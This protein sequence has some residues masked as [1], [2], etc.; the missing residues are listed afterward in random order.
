VLKGFDKKDANEY[1][2]GEASKPVGEQKLKE[3]HSKSRVDNDMSTWASESETKGMVERKKSKQSTG[4]KNM[5]PGSENAANREASEMVVDE[6]MDTGV[7]EPGSQVIAGG[8][9][10]EAI[11]HEVMGI[12]VSK[13]DSKKWVGE[14]SVQQSATLSSA[15][16]PSVTA[17][18]APP[19][20]IPGSMPPPGITPLG[21]APLSITSNLTTTPGGKL[22]PGNTP[23]GAAP[24][25][26][27]EV[28][29]LHRQ[30]K[31]MSIASLL[32]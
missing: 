10:S 22:P 3:E 20:S 27:N 30:R 9:P 4:I 7:S 28:P 8:G 15:A 1:M 25:T 23:S 6:G 5:K 12:E 32:N 2:H 14:G 21:T 29:C 19:S 18:S 16:S 17:T 11:L 13:P 24:S 31:I 26:G